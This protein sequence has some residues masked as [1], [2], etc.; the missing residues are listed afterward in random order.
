MHM[1]AGLVISGDLRFE[2]WLYL[3]GEGE[4]GKTIWGNSLIKMLGPEYAA[5]PRP[6][7]IEETRWAATC[8]PDMAEL[9]GK[10]GA[11]IDELK[12]NFPLD[13]QVA[14][15]IASSSILSAN[16]KHRDK[17]DFPNEVTLLVAANDPP[18]VSDTSHGMWRKMLVVPFAHEVTEGEKDFELKENLTQQEHRE[19]ILSMSVAG[20]V[21][22]ITN[23]YDGKDLII[24]A[25]FQQAH[26]AYRQAEHPLAEWVEDRAILES[27]AETLGADIEADIRDWKTREH[28]A[29]RYHNDLKT[30]SASLSRLLTSLGLGKEQRGANGTVWRLGISLKYPRVDLHVDSPTQVEEISE[31]DLAAEILAEVLPLHEPN[32]ECEQPSQDETTSPSHEDEDEWDYAA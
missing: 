2:K 9:P 16:P 8:D 3:M 12:K 17:F 13:G 20:Y 21:D 15:S 6:A 29:G 11:F 25:R 1:L 23:G 31:S 4:N 5:T 10:R 28:K 27:G 32:A 19:G 30:G 22:L 14:K 18:K 24:P 26:V 7:M